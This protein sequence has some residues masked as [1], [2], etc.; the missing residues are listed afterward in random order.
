MLRSGF[1]VLALSALLIIGMTGCSNSS[2]GSNDST[3]A[4]QGGTVTPAEETPETPAEETP[5][6]PGTPGTSQTPATTVTYTVTFNSNGGDAVT[7]QK[8][9]KGKTATK[10]ADPTKPNSNGYTYAFSN[11]YSNGALTTLFDFATPINADITLYAKWTESNVELTE[12]EVSKVFTGTAYRELDSGTD[13]TAGPS[14][15]YAVFGDWPQTA[16]AAYITIYD[17][18][19]VTQG[20]N[21]YYKGND[22]CWYA[23]VGS[24]YYKVEPIK[25]RVLDSTKKL[26]LAEN[27]LE[28]GDYNTGDVSTKRT[29][30][31][32]QINANNYE[33]SRI[34]AYLNGDCYYSNVYGNAELTNTYYEIGFLQTAFTSEMQNNIADTVVDNSAASTFPDGE[35][36]TNDDACSDTTDKI[37]LLSR[38]EATS[39]TYGFSS[40]SARK[41]YATDYVSEVYGENNWDEGPA[42]PWWLRSPYNDGSEHISFWYI[43]GDGDIDH[44]E[45][46]AV[47]ANGI[48]PALCLK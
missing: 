7:S 33:Y 45:T 21:T 2:G 13:G 10:P 1:S 31:G 32:I 24:K 9:E 17:S 16:K 48:V 42:W 40:D 14:A 35:T 22:D 3:P 6:T 20:A 38:Q 37:F 18:I 36:G 8:V 46:P 39:S 43:K 26:I 27:V 28:L 25:W 44:L 23:K 30:E 4:A 11:W 29:L 34:R 5:E 41:Y 19:T 47:C 15:T 12:E